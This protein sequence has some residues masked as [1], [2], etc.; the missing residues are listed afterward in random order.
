VIL[1]ARRPDALEVPARQRTRRPASWGGAWVFPGGAVD[2][3]EGERD[4]RARAG[5]LREL[6]EEANVELD[7]PDSLVRFSRWIT[8]G[9]A[10]RRATTRAL[11][12]APAPDDDPRPSTARRRGR[13]LVPPADALATTRG[14]ILLVFP[15]IKHLEQLGSFPTRDAC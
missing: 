1:S 11:L 15:T 3:D 12:P 8:P 6:A 9:R 7:E 14:E 10:S 2:T 5:R 13:A 4:D